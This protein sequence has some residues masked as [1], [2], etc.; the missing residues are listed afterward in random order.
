MIKYNDYQTIEALWNIS[1]PSHWDVKPIYSIAKLKSITNCVD[2]PLL[3]VYLD[4]GVIPFSARAEKRTNVT[5]TDLSKYQRVDP[6]DFVLNNQQAWRGSVGVSDYL[7][8]ISPAYLILELDNS[9]NKRFANYLFRSS[10]LVGQYVRSSKGVGSIQRNLYWSYLKRDLVFVPPMDEQEQIVKYLDWQLSKVNKL[11]T[12]KREQKKKLIEM[13]SAAIDEVIFHGKSR[14]N[15]TQDSGIYWLGMIPDSWNVMPLNRVCNVGASISS[16]TKNFAPEDKVPFIPM[17]NVSVVGEVDYSILRPFEEVRTGYSSFAKGDVVIAKIT[18]CFENGK[19]AC[20]SDMPCEIGYGTTEFINLRADEKITPKYL[21]YITSSRTF[22]ILGEEVMT[23][24]AGQ[25]RVPTSY[26]KNF[27]CGIPSIDEQNE[28]VDY[29]ENLLC[30]IDKGIHA[31]AN[32]INA[33]HDFKKKIVTDA[34]SGQIDVR[35]IE[36]PDYEY[37]DEEINEYDADDEME[38]EE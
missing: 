23:G 4:A 35:S 31:M 13:R 1:I 15:N 6:G 7:G 30:R 33:L 19:G 21:Y 28:L 8:I 17:E 32:E 38:E 29:L 3:S 25:K 37:V 14:K 9:F 16:M 36:I 22:R 26:V 24:S 27:E 5:S 12:E 20:M 34:V 18:P 11:I 2:L 10:F